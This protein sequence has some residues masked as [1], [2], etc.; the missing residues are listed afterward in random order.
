MPTFPSQKSAILSL[1]E[2]SD[3]IMQTKEETQQWRSPASLTFVAALAFQA[4]RMGW[5]V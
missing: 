4:Q 2:T 5:L 3:G 1:F